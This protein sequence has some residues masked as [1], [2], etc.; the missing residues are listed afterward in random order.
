MLGLQPQTTVPDDEPGLLAPGSAEPVVRIPA[1]ISLLF[2][3]I[4]TALKTQDQTGANSDVL[5]VDDALGHPVQLGNAPS[6][7]AMTKI[8]AAAN[9]GFEII[10]HNPGR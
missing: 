9:Y 3:E 4:P 7:Y 8:H 1:E 10:R 6:Q 2:V 5:I